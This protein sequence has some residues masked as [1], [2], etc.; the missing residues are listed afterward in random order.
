[1]GKSERGSLDHERLKLAIEATNDGVFDWNIATGAVSGNRRLYE[2]LGYE[3]GEIEPHVSAWE[4]ITHPDDIGRS[5]SAISEH[6]RGKTPAYRAEL[7]LRAK[8]GEWVWVVDRGKVVERD[9]RGRALRMSGTH[10]DI[11]ERKRLEL[12]LL[13]SDRMATLGTLS[14]CV[15]HEINTPLA[16]A[17]GCLDAA[18]NEIDPRRG[19]P[20]DESRLVDAI[21]VAREALLRVQ[22]IARDLHSL[23]RVEQEDKKTPVDV[24]VVLEGVLRLARREIEQRATLVRF[25]DDVPP[26]L[27]DPARLGQVFLN[28]L[29]N[30]AHAIAPGRPQDNQIE[31]AIS[32]SA[33]CVLVDVSDTGQGMEPTVR[34]RVFEPFFTTK[35][36]GAGIGL[37]LSICQSIVTALGGDISVESAPG[38]GTRFRVSLPALPRATAEPEGAPNA[39]ATTGST[40]RR[41]IL[42]VDDEPGMCLSLRMLLGVT[43][44]VVTATSAAGALRAIAAG[45][46]FDVIL[47]DLMM[48]GGS[49]QDLHRQLSL[50]HPPLARAMIFMTGGVLSA[51]TQAFLDEIPNPVLF[52]PFE[53]ERLEAVLLSSRA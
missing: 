46:E 12:Q 49:G 50:L 30:A 13:V 20:L 36:G 33:G 51:E 6:I 3:P 41:R 25:F 7:R 15:A 45:A 9:A 38:F 5:R 18:A 8:S 52:K 26:V 24:R 11:S 40:V 48:P 1:M 44:E 39:G 47:C 10:T 19:R 16:T 21:A 43:S 27:A 14:A 35:P 17:I 37:G 29:V 31:V 22:E 53:V 2:M 28:L 32:T 4:A 23:S 34:A 42:I